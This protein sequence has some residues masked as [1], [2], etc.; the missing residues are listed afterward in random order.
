MIIP[1][2][3]YLCR[4]GGLR[5]ID[6]PHLRSVMPLTMEAVRESVVET[7]K[8][9]ADLLLNEWIPECCDIVDEKRDL[10]EGWMPEAEEGEVSC[11][12]KCAIVH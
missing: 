1:T 2:F 9:G 6:I 4:Y 12:N 5:L 11:K 10:V 7:S 8:K 3:F